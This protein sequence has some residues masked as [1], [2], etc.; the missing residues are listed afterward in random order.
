MQTR[1][2]FG[3]KKTRS[4]QVLCQDPFQEIEDLPGP[5][6][7]GPRFNR[8]T[9]V[10]SEIKARLQW[11]W[12][13]DSDLATRGGRTL[14]P[15]K[16]SLVLELSGFHPLRNAG[17][18]KA[19][20]SAHP[21]CACCAERVSLNHSKMLQGFSVVGK[22][23]APWNVNYTCPWVF[24]L[25]TQ[26][27]CWV[28]LQALSCQAGSAFEMKKERKFIQVLPTVRISP[29]KYWSPSGAAS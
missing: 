3:P 22:W 17:V 10:P 5:V 20:F 25:E 21:W 8:I 9:Q 7:C 4:D 29:W 27:D 1:K 13:W 23:S 2:C 24:R 14:D 16:V 15:F 11:I 19:D 6:S 28:K 26:L 18:A 12:D